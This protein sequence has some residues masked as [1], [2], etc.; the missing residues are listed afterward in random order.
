[1]SNYTYA[2][3]AIHND[4]HKEMTVHVSGKTDMAALIRAFMTEDVMDV[5]EVTMEEMKE[6]IT[7]PVELDTPQAEA[8]F[9]KLR[10]ARM[11]DEQMQPLDMSNAEKGI[12]AFQLALR[13]NIQNLWQVF[14]TLWGTTP[15]TLRSAYNRAN[16]QRKTLLFLEKLKNVL[17]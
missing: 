6:R 3:G 9:A 14:S 5:R 12:L 2:D 1:M 7:L 10:Q 8:L 4:H 13:L 17:S 16:E 15:G 11:M